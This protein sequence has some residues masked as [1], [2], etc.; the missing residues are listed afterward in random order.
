MSIVFSAIIPASA[1]DAESQNLKDLIASIK[2]QDF[3]QDQIEILVITEGDSEQAKAIGIKRARGEICAMFCVDNFITYHNLF[4]RVYKWMSRNEISGA[5]TKYY[6]C[7]KKDNSLNRYFSLI[8]NND[9]VSF[10]V[11]K[12]DRKPMYEQNDYYVSEEIVSFPL[13]GMNLPSFGDNGFFIKRHILLEEVDLDHYYPMD[14][15]VDINKN[16]GLVFIRFNAQY[17]WHRTSEN[18][19]SFLIKRYKYARD[20]YC[21]RNDRRWKMLDTKDDYT[22]LA[23]FVASVLFIIPCLYISIRGFLKVRDWAW[24]WHWPVSLGFLITYSL[25]VCRNILKRQFVFQRS[26]VTKNLKL[27]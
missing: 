9:P 13:S 11:G 24:F 12:C 4:T 20:L 16:K 8:G 14:A 17:I 3:P 25:L 15:Y 10:Y 23:W 6:A 2:A 22:R 27:V 5:Y 26:T 1:K 19:T 18:L 7:V 21:E